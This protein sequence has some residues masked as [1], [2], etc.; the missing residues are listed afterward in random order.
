MKKKDSV[1]LFGGAIIQLICSGKPLATCF[2][3]NIH[4]LSDHSN[5]CSAIFDYRKLY[6]GKKSGAGSQ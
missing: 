5:H 2:Q 4:N 1:V 3:Y 6:S